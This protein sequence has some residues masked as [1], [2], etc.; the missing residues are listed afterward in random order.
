MDEVLEPNI[1]R[2]EELYEKKNCMSCHG[3]DGS[4]T[5][6]NSGS[7]LWSEN[8]F[9]DG[10]GMGRLTKMAGYNQNNMPIG[11]EYEFTDQ[12]AAD[13]AGTY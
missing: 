2:G 9:N 7:A 11:Q 1:D 3:A 10:A 13:L 4:G 5:G 8:S 6:A 12:E